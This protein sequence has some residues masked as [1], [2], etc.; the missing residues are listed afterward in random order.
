MT[1]TKETLVPFIIV[2]VPVQRSLDYIPK[3]QVGGCTGGGKQANYYYIL[4]CN[5]LGTLSGLNVITTDEGLLRPLPVSIYLLPHPAKLKLMHTTFS[6]RIVYMM[7]M[8]MMM[9]EEMERGVETK[10]I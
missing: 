6:S 2:A 9:P 4:S 1:I 8:M 5:K 10:D 3:I 7:M